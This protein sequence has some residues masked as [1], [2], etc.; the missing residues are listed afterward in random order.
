MTIQRYSLIQLASHRFYEFLIAQSTTQPRLP[1]SISENFQ[2]CYRVECLLTLTSA[3]ST[4]TETRLI[5]MRTKLKLSLSLLWSLC[6]GFCKPCGDQ[7]IFSDGKASSFIPFSN[8]PPHQ[9]SDRNVLL[10]ISV[11]T[12]LSSTAVPFQYVPMDT[13]STGLAISAKDLGLQGVVCDHCTN[14]T[15]YL[16]SSQIFWE[17]CWIPSTLNFSSNGSVTTANIPI[18]AV[19]S[20]SKCLNFTNGRCPPANKT[21]VIPWPTKITYMGVGFGRG[22]AQQSQALPDK[23]SLTNVIAI[24]G[25]EAGIHQGYIISQGGVQVGLTPANT[26]GFD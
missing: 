23:V 18:F 9:W 10:N 7:P 3:S 26:Q 19:T 21:D 6:S 25:T 15:E 13:G 2:D 24:D 12:S 11:R 5:N 8:Q 22:S 16:S 17:G 4:R 20:T 1:K 14:G